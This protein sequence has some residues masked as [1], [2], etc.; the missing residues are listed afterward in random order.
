MKI[1]HTY[2]PTHHSALSKNLLLLMTL[3]CLLVKKLEYDIELYTTEDIHSLIKKL[4]IPYTKIHT[5]VFS[6]ERINTTFSIPK[7][8]VYSIQDKPFIHIDL[9]TFLFSKPEIIDTEKF[10]CTF[11]E[12]L[13]EISKFNGESLYNSLD[14]FLNTYFINSKKLLPNLDKKFVSNIRFDQIPNMSF[15]SAF[16]FSVFSEASK[17]C[18]DIYEKNSSFFDDNY[19]N[20]CIIEQLFIPAAIRQLSP[21]TEFLP[22]F[23]GNSNIFDIQSFESPYPFSVI[24]NKQKISFSSEEDVLSNTDYNFNGFLHLNGYKT[25]LPIIQLIKNKINKF[26]EGGKIINLIEDY[27]S[28]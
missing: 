19:Y 2:Y 6:N 15:I 12:G 18:L 1:I 25:L 5:N 3:S 17:I 11:F 13:G 23:S 27:Y 10:Y 28:L 22:L 7:L 14:G 16:N 24:S 4:K 20:A 9:D 26:D 21:T 8:K